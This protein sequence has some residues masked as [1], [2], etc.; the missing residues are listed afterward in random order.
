MMTSTQELFAVI[1]IDKAILYS[2]SGPKDLFMEYIS[3]LLL[4]YFFLS[5]LPYN[6]YKSY[7]SHSVEDGVTRLDL[8][9]TDSYCRSLIQCW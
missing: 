3:A 2:P 8:D 5:S 9:C 6:S 4:S 7:D 1:C